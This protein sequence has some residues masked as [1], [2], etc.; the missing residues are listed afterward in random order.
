MTNLETSD[1]AGDR[2]REHTPEVINAR[3]DRLT[4]SSAEATAE[5]GR[6]AVLSRLAELDREWDVD[7]ALMV[8]F[9]VVGGAAFA[10]GMFRSRR[11]A[12]F[13]RRRNGFLY[14]LGTQLGFLFWHGAVGWCPPVPLFRRLGFRT[15]REIE[16][17]RGL[18]SASLQEP[19]TP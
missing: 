6:D 13:G 10:L 16:I 14:L 9:A 1:L 19:A 18:L 11:S 3:I 17:E 2:V 7:R 8:N 4:R 5:R 15:Q 12:V